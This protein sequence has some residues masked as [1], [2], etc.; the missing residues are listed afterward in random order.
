MPTYTVQDETTGK[1][2]TFEWTGDKDPT[3]NDMAEV[4][5]QAQTFQ[6]AEAETAAATAPEKIPTI[7]EEQPTF[8]EEAWRTITD[9]GQVYPA[10]ETAVSLVT[11]AY[12]VP[13]AGLAGLFALPFVGLEKAAGIVQK[14]QELMV[15]QPQTARGQELTQAVSSPFEAL[16]RGGEYVGEAIAEAGYPK[17]GAAVKTGIV[18]APALVG[19]R[20][21]LRKGPTAKA[22]AIRKIDA[23][24]GRAIDKGINK[25]VRPSVKGKATSSQV[26]KYRQQA[27]VA[28]SEIIRN[29]DRLTLL[30]E[31]GAPVEGLPKTLNQF[32]QA[33]EQ[34]KRNIFE[35]Y[36]RL[37]KETGKA[38]VE[39]DLRP[40]AK[41]LNTVINNKVLQDL[42]PETINY[43]KNRMDVLTGRKGY[44]ALETQEA[45]QVLNQSL[46][47]FYR[48][49]SPKLKGRAHVDA[50]IANRLRKN[51]DTAI[52]KTT[53]KDYQ[54]L[55]NKY[56]SL[57][58]VE[59]D[60]VHRSVVDARKNV[61][62]LID[63]SNIYTGYHI[64]KGI[65]AAE[66]ATFAAG[67]AAKGISHYFKMLNDPNR[68]VKNMFSTA[69]EL[70][71]KRPTQ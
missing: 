20:M 43:A 56:G 23:Q 37:A 48:D 22:G 60:V 51:L 46:E 18:G 42:S 36:D 6:P 31:T 54:A 40:I 49:P 11:S 19:G 39:I 10:A 5:A 27:R 59:K 68:I 24:M 28:V 41:E 21:M 2:V 65:L 32:S 69:E 25:A 14:G 1:T 50:L 8:G 71:A 35:E 16:E 55:K 17:V 34:V 57:R 26:V 63:F 4:F 58:V 15:Y 12:G 70:M 45:I 3:D 52:K 62:G 66:P 64:T 29:K 61:K 47:N 33:I 9:I 38:G 44:T 7:S 67:M 30:D 13:A 53:G